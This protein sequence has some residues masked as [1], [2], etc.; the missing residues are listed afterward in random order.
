MR[1]DALRRWPVAS[2]KALAKQLLAAGCEVVLIGDESDAPF[3]KEFIG[4]AVRN[5]IGKHS[6]LGSV[7][8]MRRAD[9]VVSHD[10]GPLHLARLV[11][12]PCVALFGPTNPNEFVGCDPG[13]TW[14]W[15]GE[16]LTCRPC[17][18]GRS[19]A[20]CSDNV[21][22]RSISVVRVFDAVQ[23]LLARRP[24]LQTVDA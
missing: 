10:T 11:R 21:C 12:T 23:S 3:G 14:I 16:E 13:V 18:D 17:Y 4:L 9:V 15:G 19:F 20:R 2:Y 6:L 24:E 1:E 8:L 7:Q 22:L 5:E